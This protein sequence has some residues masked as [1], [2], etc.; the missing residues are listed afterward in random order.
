MKF[1]T[2]NL[3]RKR[4]VTPSALPGIRY[5]L[6]LDADI[7]VLTEARAG[8]LGEGFHHADGGATGVAY[9]GEDERKVVIASRWPLRD[10][11][12]ELDVPTP[13][14]IVSA[15]A[16]VPDGPVRVIGVCIPWFASRVRSGEA[17]NWEDHVHFLEKLGPVLAE[18]VEAAEPVV[19]AGDFNQ[20]IP[21]SRQPA[22]VAR[23]LE[24]VFE[25]LQIP[26]SGVRPGTGCQLIDH[27]VC[28]RS[29]QV[30]RV[31]E[32]KGELEGT[33]VSDH[34]GVMVEMEKGESGLA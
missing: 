19:V 21:C 23:L 8:H 17:K 9:F 18:A 2:W 33:R 31:T 24:E 13:G 15:L 27:V 11:S 28:S 26:T 4:P 12:T 25:P 16:E 29:L 6:S 14:R 5:L 1:A 22:G 34:D 20:R 30:K 10:V 32:W 7:M 3:A